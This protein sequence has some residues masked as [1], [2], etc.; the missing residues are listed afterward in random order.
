MLKQFFER[1]KNQL[2]PF[3]KLSQK[4]LTSSILYHKLLEFMKLA[5]IVV[6]QL[7]VLGFVEDE[8]TFNIFNFMKNRL[9][10]KKA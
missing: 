10:W 1:K 6:V 7:E 4:N 5:K 2:N 8:Q 9:M 3:T